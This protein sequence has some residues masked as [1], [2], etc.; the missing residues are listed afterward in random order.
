MGSIREEFAGYQQHDSHELL[1]CVLD[2]LHEDLNRVLKKEATTAP[3]GEGVADA[4]L[5]A[6]SWATHLQR[7]DSVVVDLFQGLLKSECACTACGHASTMFEALPAGLP[8][9]LP[10][11]PIM[12]QPVTLSR[13]GSCAAAP[14]LEA[15]RLRVPRAGTV[16]DMR[17]ELAR[18]S[19]IGAERLVLMDVTRRN[20]ATELEDDVNMDFAA[21]ADGLW[22]FELRRPRAAAAALLPVV[23]RRQSK[24]S[25]RRR[26]EVFAPL[27]LL[28]VAPGSTEAEVHQ[29]VERLAVGFLSETE[30]ARWT[31]TVGCPDGAAVAA[32]VGA[33]ENVK[34]VGNAAFKAEGYAAAAEKYGMALG[35]LKE[36]GPCAAAAAVRLSLL[37]NRA[38]CNLQLAEHKLVVA[39][40]TAVL[41]MQ[42]GSP[43]NL[44]ALTSRGKA[45]LALGHHDEAEADLEAAVAQC[46][47]AAGGTKEGFEATLGTL[48]AELEAARAVPKL[49]L[50]EGLVVSF[51]M[52][53]CVEGCMRG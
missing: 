41:Q 22:A 11:P 9:E 20:V 17:A 52:A 40:A 14:R 7:H 50:S 35:F 43:C 51:C 8:L 44:K 10:L 38:L 16:A 1:T 6:A 15:V 48:T 53:G 2:G 5:A 42:H 27:A 49:P 21:N 19:G 4:A 45:L 28:E 37:N 23:Q 34:A 29:A 30:R 32:A 24:G 26:M 12:A 18:R 39:D 3:E 13:Q 33:A 25:W 31:A 47:D 46:K 36:A